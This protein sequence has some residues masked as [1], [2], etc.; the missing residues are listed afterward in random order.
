MLHHYAFPYRGVPVLIRVTQW[1]MKQTDC[2]HFEN[3]FSI[4]S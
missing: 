1:K 3:L 2:D 4:R